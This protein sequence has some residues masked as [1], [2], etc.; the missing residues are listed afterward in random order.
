MIILYY[1]AKPTISCPRIHNITYIPGKSSCEVNPGPNMLIVYT[2]T[3]DLLYS[4][5]YRSVRLVL[6]DCSIDN[7]P[8]RAEF[9]V[10]LTEG[11]TI[12]S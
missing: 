10:P 8:V 6:L 11:T 5:L 9:S 4:P 3:L 7:N 12:A 1:C 2:T